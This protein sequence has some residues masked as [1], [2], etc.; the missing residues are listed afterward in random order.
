MTA[1]VEFQ[2]VRIFHSAR[3]RLAMIIPCWLVSVAGL[4]GNDSCA[5]GSQDS[6]PNG[7]TNESAKKSATNTKSSAAATE[8]RIRAVTDGQ[9]E[10]RINPTAATWNHLEFFCPNDVELNGIKWNPNSDKRLEN[11]GETRFLADGTSF[12][13]P[14]LVVHRGRGKVTLTQDQDNNVCLHFDDADEGAAEYEL[15]LK[16][17]RAADSAD[18]DDFAIRNFSF[19]WTVSEAAG[20]RV[21]IRKSSRSTNAVIA[22]GRNE[23]TMTPEEMENLAVILASAES[24]RNESGRKEGTTRKPV[25]ETSQ[26]GKNKAAFR[27]FGKGEYDITISSAETLADNA[28]KLTRVQ[29]SGLAKAMKRATKAAAFVDEKIKL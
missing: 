21:Q 6:G 14:T 24:G 10:L 9:D 29:A 1:I 15:T 17:K 13:E 16:F 5:A 23:M 2:A 11:S 19:T 4:T 22:S 7:V 20:A 8:I 26:F 28:V 18:E 25:K 3:A 12:Q 27:F